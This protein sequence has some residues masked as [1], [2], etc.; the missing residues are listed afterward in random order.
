VQD[1]RGSGLAFNTIPPTGHQHLDAR[2]S[3][4][5]FATGITPAMCMRLTGVG[6]QYLVAFTDRDNHYF[7]GARAY[8][9]TLPAGI[10]E[11]EFLVAHALRQ[12]DPLHAADAAALP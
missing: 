11:R 12:S 3:F 4:I 6:S 7:D 9:C 5:F 1:V 10:P 8:W 2:L